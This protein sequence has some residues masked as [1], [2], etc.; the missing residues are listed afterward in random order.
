M[1]YQTTDKW[2]PD[3]S[4]ITVRMFPEQCPDVSG[5]AVRISRNTHLKKGEPYNPELYKKAQPIPAS[6]EITVEQ[7]I[8]IA[9]RHG[10]SVIKD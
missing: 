5:L 2:C 10:Y 1:H 4:G 3:A 7:A 9:R 8:L 6:R